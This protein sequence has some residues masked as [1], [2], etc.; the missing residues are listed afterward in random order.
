MVAVRTA[1]TVARNS[2]SVRIVT[3][4]LTSLSIETNPSA[5]TEGSRGARAGEA[6][7]RAE[8]VVTTLGLYPGVFCAANGAPLLRSS[9]AEDET[10]T[11]IRDSSKV[12]ELIRRL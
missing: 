3:S 7:A 9:P 11:V 4:L 8:A 12:N 5:R 6:G 1:S 2:G 10:M